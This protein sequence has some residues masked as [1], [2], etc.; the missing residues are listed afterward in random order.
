LFHVVWGGGVS[1]G[2]AARIP[3]PPN[4]FEIRPDV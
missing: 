4:S 2:F 3:H 1:G